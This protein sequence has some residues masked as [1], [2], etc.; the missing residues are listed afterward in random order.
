[1]ALFKGVKKKAPEV[2][3]RKPGRPPKRIEVPAPDALVEEINALK[4][5]KRGDSETSLNDEVTAIVAAH[6]QEEAGG[7]SSSNVEAMPLQDVARSERVEETL[8]DKGAARL[9]RASTYEVRHGTCRHDA[10]RRH[11]C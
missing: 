10:T 4:R 2:E 6:E 1:M 7:G 9:C 11:P 8:Q 5:V 3:K